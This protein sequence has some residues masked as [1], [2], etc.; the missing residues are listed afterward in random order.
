MTVRL[1]VHAAGA[2][3][4]DASQDAEVDLSS[5]GLTKLDLGT[6]EVFLVSS[7]SSPSRLPFC[8]HTV[9]PRLPSLASLYFRVF[10]FRVFAE[11]GLC[12]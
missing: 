11:K 9:R 7:A 6:D 12:R 3:A 5:S 4:G 2:G 10:D 8:P 1:S